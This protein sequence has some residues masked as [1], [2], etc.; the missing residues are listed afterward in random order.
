MISHKKY[1]SSPT[2]PCSSHGQTAPTIQAGA[3]PLKKNFLSISLIS[4]QL[5][6][7][8]GIYNFGGW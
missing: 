8:L 2:Q 3:R 4:P 7:V 6:T 1:S 5:F